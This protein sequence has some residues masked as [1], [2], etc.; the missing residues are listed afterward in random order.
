MPVI[1]QKDFMTLTQ[2]ASLCKGCQLLFIDTFDRRKQELNGPL[3]WAPEIFLHSSSQSIHLFWFQTKKPCTL[4]FLS[5][6]IHTPS[7]CSIWCLLLKLP[8]LKSHII[9]RY[10]L[11]NII[12]KDIF[13][14][15]SVS[16]FLVPSCKAMFSL[17]FWML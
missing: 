17:T 14:H 11:I 16:Y 12:F 10:L 15:F 7:F 13:N 3:E 9:Q 4:D 2:Q 1:K 6:I 8:M 5:L